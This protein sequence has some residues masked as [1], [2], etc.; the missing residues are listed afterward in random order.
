MTEHE[1]TLEWPDG[2]SEPISVSPRESVLEAAGREGVRLPADCRKGT[3]ITCV[4]QVVGLEDGDENERGD[5]DSESADA[6]AAFDYRRRPAALTERERGAGY[7]LLC[8]AMPQTDCRVRV[9]P[10]V[11]SEVGDS[12]WS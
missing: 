7:V 8:I 4:G 9:G 1:L 3:C 2:R 12:P 10:M 11:R 6:A 5:D